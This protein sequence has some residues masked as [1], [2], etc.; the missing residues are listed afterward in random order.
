MQKKYALLNEVLKRFQDAGI[1]EDLVL[2]GS[3]CLLFYREYFSPEIFQP[4]I[5]TRDIDFLVPRITKTNKK[6]DIVKLLK[7]DGFIPTFSAS[8]Y[9]RLEHPEMMIEFLVPERGKGTDK[10]YPL[11]HLGMNAQSLRFLDYLLRNTI[12]IKS[13]NLR[14]NVPHPAAFGLHKLIISGR[15]KSEAKAE[16]EVGEAI[17]VLR[18]LMESGQSEEIKEKFQSMPLSWRKKVL[19][20]LKNENIKELEEILR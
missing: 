15:R 7:E 8:G 18:A 11:S 6:V 2:V 20:T 19:R 3:W 14:I 1:L 17:S 4:S 13:G 10:P 5:R 9:L 12:T 16:K